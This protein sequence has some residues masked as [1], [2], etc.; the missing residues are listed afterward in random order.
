MTA[1]VMDTCKTSRL[2]SSKA[3]VEKTRRTRLHYFP[4]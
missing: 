1:I 3:R 4:W 2:F